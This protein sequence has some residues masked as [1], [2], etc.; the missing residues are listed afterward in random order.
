MIFNLYGCA[1]K[2]C[3]VSHMTSTNLCSKI[4]FLLNKKKKED[5]GLFMAEK[6]HGK[7]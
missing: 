7:A 4:Y 5:T 1:Y 6:N 3:R 2:Q